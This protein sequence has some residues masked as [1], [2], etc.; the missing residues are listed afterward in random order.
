MFLTLDISG[1]LCS[2][3]ERYT[4]RVIKGKPMLLLST[5]YRQHKK[6]ISEHCLKPN[7]QPNK[8]VIKVTTYLDIDSNIK[9]ILD[10]LQE[11]GVFKNDRQ[12]TRL[13]VDKIVNKKGHK[14]R[15]E[16]WVC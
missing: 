11:G 12:I 8:V 1:K 3:N 4:A 15:Y 10:G 2:I 7:F 16:V 13:E 9:L 5:K 14:D 6:Y